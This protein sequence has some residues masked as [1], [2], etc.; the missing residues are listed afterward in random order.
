MATTTRSKEEGTSATPGK[1]SRARRRAQAN[2][3]VPV[4]EADIVFHDAEDA[5][6]EKTPAADPASAPG[7][8]ADTEFVTAEAERI[9]HDATEAEL[10]A[11]ES[12]REIGR[13]LGDGITVFRDRKTS[14]CTRFLLRELMD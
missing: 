3:S 13:P 11:E 6:P 7:A 12:A 8:A 9:Q 14:P 5:P 10:Q 4:P 1:M 2:A